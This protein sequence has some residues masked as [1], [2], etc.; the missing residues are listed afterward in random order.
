MSFTIEEICTATGGELIGRYDRATPVK[1]VST[2]TRTIEKGQ[3]FIPLIGENFD[4]HKFIQ[5]AALKG[6]GAVITQYPDVDVPR[7][8]PVILVKDTLNALQDIAAFH[9]KRFDIPIVAV[10]G[11]TGK[12]TTKDMIY[13]VLS[14]RYK[15]LRTEGNLNNEI[16]LP[17]TLLR[18]NHSHEIA[19]VEMGMSGFGEIH[20][21][22][23]IARPNLGIITNIGLS[24]IEKLGS[25]EN[26]LKAKMELFDFFTPECTAILNGDDELLRGIGDKLPFT[27]EYFGTDEHVNYRASRIN[28]SEDE[29]ITYEVNI[30]DKSYSIDINVPGRHNIYN[31]LAAIAVG[32][33]F[34]LRIDEIQKGLKHFK[35][36]AMR[37][38]IINTS[39]NIKIIDDAYNASPDSM[40]AS[41]AILSQSKG[42][43][44][45]AILG[46]MLELGHYSEK[47]HRDVG[48]AVVEHGIDILITRGK[49][50]RWIGEQAR[51]LGMDAK[52]IYNCA[53]N[54]D[55]INLLDTMVK[56]GDTILVKGSRGMRMEEIVSHLVD[57][58]FCQD[59]LQ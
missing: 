34:G 3:L 21:L 12:T 38:N 54:R 41:I 52:N 6:A 45:I 33:H 32:M 5:D 31:S 39:N 8:I 35:P 18:L 25:R 37:L 30:K 42:N 48:T 36:G 50:S 43:R 10:T 44:K 15:V 55:V 27:V 53:D 1:G 57:R 51:K 16:G 58:E 56:E 23:E 28:I 13:Y 22:A 4:G 20:R 29:K 49:D 47:A 24:H 40:I 7:E 9:R 14:Q 11:S 59:S 26:I 46:D 17:H 19:V 2:D